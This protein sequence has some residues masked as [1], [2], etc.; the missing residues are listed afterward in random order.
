MRIPCFRLHSAFIVCAVLAA[1]VAQAQDVRANARLSVELNTVSQVDA[2]CQLTFVAS[3]EHPEG[4][5]SVVFET[6]LFETS[7]AVNRLTL[8]DFGAIPAGVPRVRQFVVPDLQ[9]AS[10]GRLLI[11]GVSACS[12][13]GLDEDACAEGLSVTSRTEVEV[14]G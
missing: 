3:S 11:N 1:Q 13:P 8:F 6:V 10:L 14:L 4:M 2:G 5:E 7:G 12:V 9:C